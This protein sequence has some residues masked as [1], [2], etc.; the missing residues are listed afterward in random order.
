M[1]TTVLC[2]EPAPAG[3][4]TPAAWAAAL[5]TSDLSALCE[6]TPF[7]VA[8]AIE[9]AIGVYHG[10]GGCVAEMAAAYGE[11]PETATRRMRWA[12]T[13]IA[14]NPV[15]AGNNAPAGWLRASA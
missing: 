15:F 3:S 2:Q 1:S 9:H 5:F 14:G 12:R 4:A 10:I 7:E 8:A 13:V 11:H 6:H